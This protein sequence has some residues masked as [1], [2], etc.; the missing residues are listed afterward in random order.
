MFHA[1]A[2]GSRVP[3][4]QVPWDIAR[5]QSNLR[6]ATTGTLYY[7]SSS[8]YLFSYQTLFYEFAKI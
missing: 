3:W 6:V 7:Q 4:L 8:F 1:M 2:V 5:S